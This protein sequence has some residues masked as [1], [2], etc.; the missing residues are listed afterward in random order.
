MAHEIVS[1]T[2][3]FDAPAAGIFAVLAD[4][5]NSLP[6]QACLVMS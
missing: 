5:A 6:H 3:V 1:A 2:T 4:P